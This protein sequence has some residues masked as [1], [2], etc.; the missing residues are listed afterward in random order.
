MGFGEVF[1][2]AMLLDAP[3][4]ICHNNDYGWWEIEEKLSMARDK[5]MNMWAEY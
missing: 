5:G 3:L 4:L 1:T 2:N